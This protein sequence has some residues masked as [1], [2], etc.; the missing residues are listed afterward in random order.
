MKTTTC[1]LRTLV[2]A[3]LTFSTMFASA[4]QRTTGVVRTNGNDP[5]VGANISV[6]G[7]TT[8]TITDIDGRFELMTQPGDVLLITIPDKEKKFFSANRLCAWG[9]FGLTTT[10]DVW[11]RNAS[12]EYSFVGGGVGM[13]YQR[14][15]NRL[16]LTVGIEFRSLNYCRFFGS[17]RLD[18]KP[19][20]VSKNVMVNSGFI[21]LPVMIG[22]EFSHF[23]WQVGG[24]IGTALY[25]NYDGIAFNNSAS[26]YKFVRVA[27]AA[28]I[29]A[30]FIHKSPSKKNGQEATLHTNYKI[31]VSAEWGFEFAHR[32]TNDWTNAMVGLKFSV[33]FHKELKQ[34][35]PIIKADR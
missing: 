23:Y 27:P 34:S 19:E 3:L 20:N 21:Q 8:S 6:E 35:E 25:N 7:S 11:G 22:M 33:G 10:P 32:G 5:I 14:V 28:E 15:S 1:I 2:L 31:G 30:S 26:E 12:G 18:N 29:G 24:K 9:D 16:L 4:Q 17:Y 13:G